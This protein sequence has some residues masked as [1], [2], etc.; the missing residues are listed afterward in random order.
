MSEMDIGTMRYP[1]GGLKIKKTNG[2]YY[3]GVQDQTGIEYDEI[4][5]E[6]YKMLERRE[7]ERRRLGLTMIEKTNL[8][9]I[10]DTHTV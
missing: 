2:R 9:R 8:K 10:F 6:L 4:T 7:L 3:W 5:M 1:T